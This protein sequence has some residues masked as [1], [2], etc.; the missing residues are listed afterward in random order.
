VRFFREGGGER[1]LRD[2][3]GMLSVGG[4]DHTLIEQAVKD[5]GLEAQWGLVQAGGS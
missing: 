1:H 2:I 5:R 3:R 4:V